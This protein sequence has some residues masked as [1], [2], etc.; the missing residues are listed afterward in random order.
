MESSRASRRHRPV[1][2]T[3]IVV[4]MWIQGIFGIIAGLVAFFERNDVE[5]RGYWDASSGTITAWGIIAILVGL[6]TIFL[7][8][9]LGR[10]SNVVRIFVGVIAAFNFGVGVWGL[11]AFAGTAW[12]NAIWQ[13][14][15]AGVVLYILF[16]S[17]SSQEFFGD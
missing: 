11:F 3:V 9:S 12:A 17:R 5:L 13:M 14:I 8:V 4:L 6:A 2:I 10:G 16:G 15:I 7:A 1:G